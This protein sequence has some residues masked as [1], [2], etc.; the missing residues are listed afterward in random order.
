[1]NIH[2]QRT[3]NIKIRRLSYSGY[4]PIYFF[5]NRKCHSLTRSTQKPKLP[6]SI[7]KTKAKYY[8]YNLPLSG[9]NINKY[10]LEVKANS[11][12]YTKCL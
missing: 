2:F 4:R 1:M 5:G 9:V 7:I 12:T 8:G 6:F 3:S 11:R 10:S